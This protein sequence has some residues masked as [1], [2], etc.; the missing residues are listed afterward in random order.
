MRRGG[1]SP[2]H[3]SGFGSSRTADLRVPQLGVADCRGSTLIP[4]GVHAAIR[5]NGFGHMLFVL[6]VHKVDVATR[7]KWSLPPHGHVHGHLKPASLIHAP[8]ARPRCASAVVKMGASIV[9]WLGRAAASAI[10]YARMGL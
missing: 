7:R 3:Y 9:R 5:G 4:F 1:T 8:N 2:S 10:P 6:Q